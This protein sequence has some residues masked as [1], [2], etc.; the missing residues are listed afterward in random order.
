MKKLISLLLTAALS[1]TLALSLASCGGNND[2]TIKVGASPTPHAVILEHVKDAL[3]EKGWTLEIVTFDDYVLPNTALS[4]GELDANY[5]QHEPYLLDFNAQRGTDI[6]KAADVHYEPLGLYGKEVSKTDYAANAKTGYTIIVPNDGSNCTRALLLLQDEGFITLK[7]G[8]SATDSL[9]DLDITDKKGNT[10]TLAA[11]ETITGLLAESNAGTL[12][13]VNG[14]YAISAGLKIA[15][16]LASE[17]ADGASAKTY[18]NIIA[19]K[20]GNEN[21][22]KVKALIEAL[23]TKE[24]YDFIIEQ[25]GGAVVPTYTV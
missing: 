10:I 1:A 15:D 17:K 2:K 9:S 21:N 18:S 7:A 6:V 23:Q 22:E 13:V 3:S 16:A 14:N 12:A 20:R 8:V 4:D 5:F 24:V 11:A 25:F 19:V